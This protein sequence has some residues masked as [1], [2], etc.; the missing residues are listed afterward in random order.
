MIYCHTRRVG[1]GQ[2]AIQGVI[3]Q[4]YAHTSNADLEDLPQKVRVD[5]ARVRLAA[6]GRLPCSNNATNGRENAHSYT[7]CWASGPEPELGRRWLS[8]SLR[9]WTGEHS[10]HVQE[11]QLQGASV[12]ALQDGDYIFGAMT[13]RLHGELAHRSHNAVGLLLREAC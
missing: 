9:P 7:E 6:V 12:N 11:L 3:V 4:E 1:V 2:Y 13:R 5:S 10:T 8:V